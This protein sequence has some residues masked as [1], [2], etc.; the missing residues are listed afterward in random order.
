[1]E[2]PTSESASNQ[3]SGVEKYA[4]GFSRQ[5]RRELQN[6]F[7]NGLQWLEQNP[8]AYD[9]AL[10]IFASCMKTDPMGAVY[11]YEFLQTLESGYDKGLY[12]HK[13][14]QRR[15]NAKLVKRIN[16]LRNNQQ[17]HEILQQ[18]PEAL[19]HNARHEQLL[20]ELAFAAQSIEAI[21]TQWTYLEFALK[22]FPNSVDLHVQIIHAFYRSGRYDDANDHMFNLILTGDDSFLQKILR[23][24][25]SIIT[26]QFP[27]REVVS[28]IEALRSSIRENSKQHHSWMKLC[29]L[30]ED[31]NLYSQAISS[32]Q[33]AGLALG[34]PSLW[35]QKSLELRLHQAES[36][37]TF[38]QRLEATDDLLDDLQ[39]EV[40]RIRIEYYQKIS[41]EHPDRSL[42]A[43][44]LAWCLVGTGNWYEAIKL[45]KEIRQSQEISHLDTL[46][47]LLGLGEAQQAVRR[48]DDA[49]NTFRELLDEISVLEL[50][51]ETLDKKLSKQ[52]P[53]FQKQSFF[54][55]SLERIKTLAESMNQR[56]IFDKCCQLAQKSHVSNNN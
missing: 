36:R 24:L 49:M 50:E 11:T 25:P 8:P 35:K 9:N 52:I 44:Q 13:W 20:L 28:E 14:R 45:F 42:P 55:R 38:H 39:Q 48:F 19:Y 17:W 43:I 15:R 2:P 21:Q 32:C 51:K 5:K 4:G 41:S 16:N 23:A 3:F 31:L 1:M 54:K 33:Q 37:H 27:G 34:N 53:G 46:A 22:Y 18:A 30:L 7:E 10:R 56:L 47:L 29:E 6:Q 26:K 12:R 40:W